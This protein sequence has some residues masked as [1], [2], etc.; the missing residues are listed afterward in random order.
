MKERGGKRSRMLV[1]STNLRD[2]LNGVFGPGWVECGGLI[3]LAIIYIW[4]WIYA[5]ILLAWC[6]C[7]HGLYP[8][9]LVWLTR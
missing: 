3:D 1:S 4:S 5:M 2:M 7:L 6:V 8:Y 9:R